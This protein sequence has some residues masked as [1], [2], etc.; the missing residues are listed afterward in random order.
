MVWKLKAYV[1]EPSQTGTGIASQNRQN[2]LTSL[3]LFEKELST[4]KNMIKEE[5]W[6]KLEEWMGDA[7]TLHKI[8]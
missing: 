1:P 2:L 8:L 6:D 4:C 7:T 3:E 5:K